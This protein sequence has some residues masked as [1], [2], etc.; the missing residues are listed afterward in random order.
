MRRLVLLIIVALIP[1]AALM[2]ADDLPA[3]AYNSPSPAPPGARPPAPQPGDGSQKRLPA[4]SGVAQGPHAGQ[5]ASS[6]KVSA[7][8]QPITFT[9]HVAPIIFGRCAP[10]HRP[11]GA[12]PFSLLT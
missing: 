10:C 9:Q 4:S 12:A 2:A 1:A 3:W 8:T 11:G 5:A 7:V 6:E